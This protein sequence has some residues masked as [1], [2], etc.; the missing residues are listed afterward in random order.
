ME[1]SVL[2]VTIASVLVGLNSILR[3]PR[4]RANQ[5]GW[6]TGG[7]LLTWHLLCLSFPPWAQSSRARDQ[8]QSFSCILHPLLPSS[9]HSSSPA[10]PSMPNQFFCSALEPT[11]PNAEKTRGVTFSTFLSCSSYNIIKNP[12]NFNGPYKI[13]ALVKAST[14]NYF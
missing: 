2:G 7:S 9:R 13:C 3:W 8:Q 4:V 6:P 1:V 11:H 10:C 14:D 12:L 5:V